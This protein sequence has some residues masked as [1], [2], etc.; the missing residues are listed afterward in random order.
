VFLR[1]TGSHSG[2]R[3]RVGRGMARCGGP[4]ANFRGCCVA[5]F[6]VPAAWREWRFVAVTFALIRFKRAAGNVCCWGGR[7]LEGWVFFL[8]L[9][10]R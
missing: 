4:A 10:A 5:V 8:I 6:A 9:R 1:V 3:V 7:W 2:R